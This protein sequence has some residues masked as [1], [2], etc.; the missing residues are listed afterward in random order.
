MA[1]VCTWNWLKTPSLRTIITC[2][3]ISIKYMQIN[4]IYQRLWKYH[5]LDI[6]Y[7][8]DCVVRHVFLYSY[9][10]MYRTVTCRLTLCTVLTIF[11]SVHAVRVNGTID[12]IVH[13]HWDVIDQ[14]KPKKH[15]SRPPKIYHNKSTGV[16]NSSCKHLLHWQIVFIGNFRQLAT[17]QAI[18][19]IHWWLDVTVCHCQCCYVC[20]CLLTWRWRQRCNC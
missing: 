5:Q 15:R 14:L 2:T 20:R 13:H 1:A 17:C 8:H 10:Y 12:Y 7:V 9:M 11:T 3:N 19:C 16:H 4:I 18:V 6:L